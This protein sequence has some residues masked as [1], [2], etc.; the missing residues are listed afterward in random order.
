MGA[1]RD[2]LYSTP[3][4]FP[5]SVDKLIIKISHCLWLSMLPKRSP[6]FLPC[7]IVAEGTIWDERRLYKKLS[8][9]VELERIEHIWSFFP[10]INEFQTT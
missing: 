5:T 1:H 4:W 9:G 3:K 10:I 6:C 8:S 2:M 7:H